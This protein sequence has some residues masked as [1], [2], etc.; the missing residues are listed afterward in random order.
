[1]YREKTLYRKD[2]DSEMA[3]TI[4]ETL[5]EKCPGEKS[6]AES[7]REICGLIGEALGMTPAEIEKLK[8]AG[9]LHDIGKVVLD[10]ETLNRNDGL[11]EEEQNKKGLLLHP[12]AGYR[13]LN[14]FDATLEYAEA[15]FCHHEHWDGTGV[16]NGIGGQ[17]IPLIARILRVAESWDRLRLQ[18][19]NTPGWERRAVPELLEQSGTA[20]DPKIAEALA[21]RVSAGAPSSI[22]PARNSTEGQGLHSRSSGPY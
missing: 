10:S 9:Y 7:V 5:H 21:V 3:D 18:A 14:L 4:M 15:V 17:N 12:A 20:L 22:A 1:M 11:V 13:I 19:G 2:I 16:P 8:T 6:H